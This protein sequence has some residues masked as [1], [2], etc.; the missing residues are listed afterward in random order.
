M[1]VRALAIL[2]VALFIG[3]IDSNVRR[4]RVSLPGGESDIYRTD[5]LAATERDIAPLSKE[6]END[7]KKGLMKRGGFFIK[8]DEAKRLHD[9]G[10]I[11]FDARVKEEFDEGHVKGA[12]LIDPTDPKVIEARKK[13]DVLKGFD[14]RLPVVV[15][16][17]GGD[18]DSSLLVALRLR[19][20]G[21][22]NVNVFEEGFPE[23][24]KKG[25]PHE[26]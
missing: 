24:K 3:L 26:P 17:N 10:M 4:F 19:D 7:P 16:C 12:V 6:D 14:P 21:F 25:Y 18:C 22:T 23:W 5:D 15:Y 1:V 9:L 2:G 13:P 8:I 20:F 11:F